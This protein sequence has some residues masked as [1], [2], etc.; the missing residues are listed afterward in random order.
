MS[1]QVTGKNLEVGEAFQTYVS[2]KLDVAT[3]KYVG[4]YLSAHVRVEKER[5][6]FNTNCSV[7][8]R[9]GLLLEASGEGV[10]AYGSTDAAFERLEKRMRRY[11]RRLKSHHHHG[12]GEQRDVVPQSVVSDYVIAIDD[13]EDSN[14]DISADSSE[15][16][17]GADATG[18]PLVIAETERPLRQISVSE[19]VMQL[20]L[21]DDAFLVFRNP[22]S[23]AINVVYRRDDG[24]IGWI[25][26]GQNAKDGA[27]AA[28]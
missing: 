23:G 20:D 5:G 17:A 21:T 28:S 11:K 10:D 22:S 16:T 4:Q 7:R 27:G 9:T 24:N 3:E 18:N 6:K 13:D 15:Q 14:D 12:D 8:L 25:D 1:L 2:D 19:A 26:P